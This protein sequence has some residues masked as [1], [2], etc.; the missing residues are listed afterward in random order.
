MNEIKSGS[1]T[2][3]CNSLSDLV[4]NKYCSKFKSNSM[5]CKLDNCFGR[6][7]A[8]TNGILLPKSSTL[9]FFFPIQSGLSTMTAGC[10][11]RLDLV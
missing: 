11:S 2:V 9:L 4:L 3:L 8:L 1:I 6:E 5:S 10:G 7:L